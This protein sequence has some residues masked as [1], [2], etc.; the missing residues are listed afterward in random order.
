M[1]HIV[2]LVHAFVSGWRDLYRVG[3]EFPSF[4]QCEAARP[5]LA[6]DFKQLM[7]RRYQEP[8]EIE[9]KCANLEDEI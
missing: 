7:E 1:F 6:D 8:F 9:S 3:T 2:I 5:D 4:D